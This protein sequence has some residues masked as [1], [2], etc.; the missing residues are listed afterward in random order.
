MGSERKVTFS[1]NLQI[2]TVLTI[3][4]TSYKVDGSNI[5][6]LSMDLRQWG[7]S[8]SISFYMSN[9]P[10]KETLYDNFIK[11]DP[12]HITI[13]VKYGLTTPKNEK[14]IPL[15]LKGVVC[16]RAYHEVSGSYQ[17]DT[18]LKSHPVLYRIYTITFT[19]PAAFYWKQ[20]FPV[21]LYV[22]STYKAVITDQ[23]TADITINYDWD[24]VDKVHPQILVSCSD[25]GDQASFYDFL[26]NYIRD[27]CGYLIYD[28]QKSCY[29]V[30]SKRPKD[31]D[32][33]S[34]W[35]LQLG[36]HHVELPRVN[37]S[38][39]S[40]I[41]AVA[42]TPST[43]AIDNANV[44]KPLARDLVS[45]HTTPQ[46]FND[47]ASLEKQK[48]TRSRNPVRWGYSCFP[49]QITTPNDLVHFNGPDWSKQSYLYKK[50]Y[51]ID[52]LRLDAQLIEDVDTDTLNHPN[53][54]YEISYQIDGLLDKDTYISYPEVNASPYP[55]HVEA[56]VYSDQGKS[57]EAVYMYAD[58][59][60]TSIKYYQCE[61]PA[62]NKLKVRVRHEPDNLNGQIYMPPYKGQ[63]VL[64]GIFQNTSS[65][66]AYLDWRTYAALPLEGQGNHVVFGKSQTDRTT[67]KHAYTNNIP[68]LD[69]NRTLQKDTQTISMGDGFIVLHAKEE[70]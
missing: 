12:I 21:K 63:K 44:I 1:D 10:L 57:D 68:Q 15:S 58:D 23:K 59:K 54:T 17:E 20:S 64:L 6:S 69:I 11:D 41:N 29:S 55:V 16:D 45:I 34:R 65:I 7:F 2:N 47:H 8:G 14:I 66:L 9:H 25:M 56:L 27:H 50:K 70:K 49:Y 36:W 48:D 35:A 13:A 4:G 19:D 5:K 39:T 53:G 26:I 46:L 60:N 22:D 24:V 18:L 62:W 42:P 32:P 51:R 52:R 31:K 30:A 28:Y 3:K 37:Y 33:V 67:I 38:K 61:I 43:V 40:L